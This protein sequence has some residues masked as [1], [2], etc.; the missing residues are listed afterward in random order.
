[1]VLLGGQKMLWKKGVCSR[2]QKQ[3][4]TAFLAPT[5]VL[6]QGHTEY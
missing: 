6:K 1:M 5:S 4:N 3:E 2:S